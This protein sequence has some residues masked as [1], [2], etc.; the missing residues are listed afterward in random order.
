MGRQHVPASVRF[1]LR[2]GSPRRRLLHRLWFGVTWVAVVAFLVWALR[3]AVIEGYL[4]PAAND[5]AGD[6][7]FAITGE[8]LGPGEWWAGRGLFYG[9]VFVMEWRFI[10]YPGYLSIADVAHID[11]AL[12]A[13]AFG[14]TWAALFD[15]FRPRLFVGLLAAWL[16]SYLTIALLAAVQHLEVLELAGLALAL[17]LLQRGRSTAAGLSLGLAVATKTLPV[18]FLPYLAIMRRWR[19]LGLATGL[20]GILFL[21]A[22]VVQGV[23]PWDGVAML[24]NQGENLAKTKATEYELGLRAFLIRLL[25]SGQGNPTAEQVQFA[26]GVH[27]AVSLATVLL[28]AV[29][30]GRTAQTRRSLPLAWGL[31][32]TTMLIVAPVTHIFYYVFLLPAWTALL[33]DL[34]D[35]PLGGFTAG[36]WIA[37]VTSY[38]L[39]GF[40][41]P[42]LLANRLFGVGQVMLD[43]WLSFIPLALLLTASALAAALLV[44]YPRGRSA[45]R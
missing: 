29:V 12:L 42:I 40:D 25:T 18:V 30:V 20:A 28:T 34:I 14:C 19:T 21:I 2:T 1:E 4:Y 24:L 16:A 10:L 11:I 26:F 35:R 37:L 33:A 31:I 8:T 27:A 41:Q 38:V 7:K 39:M 17:L 5:F 13:L 45:A 3:L 43:H 6:F 9:P 23:A 44:D 32:A 15:R 22:C 36:Q